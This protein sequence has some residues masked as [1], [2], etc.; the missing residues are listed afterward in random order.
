MTTPTNKYDIQQENVTG[1]AFDNVHRNAMIQ[2]AIKGSS[3]SS[4]SSSSNTASILPLARKTGTTIAG[5]VFDNGVVLGADTRATGGAEV[6]E[7]NCEK[8]HYLAPN[9]YCCGAGTAADTEKTTALVQSNLQLLRY[10]MHQTEPSR[11]ITACTQLKRFLHRYQGHISAALVLGGCDIDGPHIYQIY[12]HGST[13]KLP[14]TT[15]GSGSLAAMAVFESSWRS[16][17]NETDAVALVQRAIGA[18]I[19]NDLGSG[20][21]CDICIIRNDQTVSYHRNMVTPNDITPLRNRVQHSSR[22]TIPV[23]ATPVIQ[24][25]FNKHMP[26]MKEQFASIDQETKDDDDNNVNTEGVAAMEVEA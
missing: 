21:N 4:S 14:Y 25:T 6:A 10:Q 20:S 7:K 2:K 24:T 22:F 16:A 13:G 8:I 23:G 18:G 12:P 26:S 17:M 15:M 1:F 3:S 9:I 5:I 19:F 11:V